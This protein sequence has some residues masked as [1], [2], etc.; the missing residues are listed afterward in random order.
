MR[1]RRIK[2]FSDLDSLYEEFKTKDKPN[3]RKELKKATIIGSGIGVG[4]G[5]GIGIAKKKPILGATIGTIGGG[6]GGAV[7]QKKRQ[8]KKYED[9]KKELQNILE[10]FKTKEEKEKFLGVLKNELADK[11]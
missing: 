5:T 9:N 2:V 6:L 11:N 1:I 3:A 4:L 7:I 10:G 8:D